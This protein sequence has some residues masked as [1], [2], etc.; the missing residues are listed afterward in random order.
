MDKSKPIKDI[1]ELKVEITLVDKQFQSFYNKMLAIALDYQFYIDPRINENTIY[2]IRDNIIYRLNSSKFHFELLL[3]MATHLDIELTDAYRKMEIKNNPISL[4][5][6]FDQRVLQINFL[7]DSIFFHLGSSFDYLS[8]LVEFICCT[9]KN[10]DFK[11]GQLA[12]SARDKKNPFNQNHIA[13]TIDIIDREFVNRLYDHRSYIIHTN[14]DKGP[15][16]FIINV[17]QAECEAHIFSSNSFNK[18]FKELKTESQ[19]YNLTI[20]YSLLWVIKKSISCLIEVLYELKSFM[21]NN[22]KVI[23]PSMFLKGPNGEILPPSLGF[24]G[25]KT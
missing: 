7:A 12:K 23:V 25:Q 2:K 22:K 17:I 21:E 15:S 3:D 8:T 18:R 16:N 11:W 20:Q 4:G 9:N 1:N 5:I 6:H 19:D 13:K 14:V 10:K 24:W